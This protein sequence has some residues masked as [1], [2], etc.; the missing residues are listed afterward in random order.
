MIIMEGWER[1][2]WEYRDNDAWIGN[3]EKRRIREV[4]TLIASCFLG[5]ILSHASGF[6]QSSLILN[7]CHNKLAKPNKYCF[8]PK[9]TGTFL[10]SDCITHHAM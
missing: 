4:N 1:E 3:R 6:A 8:I 5:I 9:E 10:L 7:Y 2:N